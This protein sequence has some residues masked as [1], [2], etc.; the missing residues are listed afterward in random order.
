V[1]SVNNYAI[2]NVIYLGGPDIREYSHIE[3]EAA[4]KHVRDDHER[5][6]RYGS[7]PSK[8]NLANTIVNAREMALFR[9]KNVDYAV[10]LSVYNTHGIEYA[11]TVYVIDFIK[12]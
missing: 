9:I 8:I 12:N 3:Y 6:D 5:K 4:M 1:V 10:L 11:S 2:E 7:T